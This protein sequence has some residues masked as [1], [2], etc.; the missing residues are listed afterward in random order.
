MAGA[1]CGCVEGTSAGTGVVI[2]GR[3]SRAVYN[4]T[5]GGGPSEDVC[6]GAGGV[7]RRFVTVAEELARG[8]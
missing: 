4:P 8:R 3:G 1:G 6:L 2:V 5:S 7:G